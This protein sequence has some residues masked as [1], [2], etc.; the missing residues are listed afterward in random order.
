MSNSLIRGLMGASALVAAGV[1]MAGS[2]QA[3]TINGGGSSLVGPYI[4][5]AG[6]CYGD[7]QPLYLA[8]SAPQN[9]TPF[10]YTD[11]AT[12]VTTDCAVTH[13]SPGNAINYMSAGSG[14]GRKGFATHNPAQFGDIDPAAGVQNLASVEYAMSDAG[15]SQADFNVYVN[16]GTN[17]DGIQI[18]AHNTAP[19]GAQVANPNDAYGAAIQIPALIAPVAIAFDPVY[20]KTLA[21]DGVTLTEYKLRLKKPVKAT[22]G[23]VST[24]VGGLQ[25]DVDTYCKIFNGLITNWNDPALKALNG[26]QDLKDVA[27]P[28]ALDVP[29]VLVGRSDSSGTT[30]IFTRHLGAVCATVAGNQ[31]NTTTATTTLPAGLQGPTYDKSKTNTDPTALS[32]AVV[33][34]KFVRANGN[35]GVAKYIDFTAAPTVAGT[36]MT[37]GRIGYAGA[38]FTL[39][40]SRTTLAGTAI[41]SIDLYYATLKNNSGKFV[42]PTATGAQK[43]FGP[44]LPP[45]YNPTTG[46][47]DAA[48]TANGLRANPADWVQGLSTSSPL[49]NP[50]DPS[51]YNIVGTAN[52]LTYSCYVSTAP[53]MTG[54]LNWYYKD[55]KLVSDKKTGLLA[56]SGFSAMPS[57]WVK[58]IQETFTKPAGAAKLLNL[59]IAPANTGTTGPCSTTSGHVG[60]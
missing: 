2:A 9:P 33:A 25:L 1:A 16:G 36:S 28:A 23:G 15:V 34:S 29:I 39:P 11:P 43:A 4:R 30:S 52:F 14:A 26:G 48:Y 57:V 59:Y 55:G 22:I 19:V 7:I 49:A 44:V 27:D 3:A 45:Q 20:K 13:V 54:F 50:N 37:W 46:K 40:A 53:L 51:A 38:D 32:G 24:T 17:S 12:L 47:F 18:A 42:G 6:D 8:G 35:D 60:A 56:T 5:Q 41:A 21:A 31:Y 10:V 58:A